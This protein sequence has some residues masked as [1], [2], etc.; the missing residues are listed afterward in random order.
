MPNG[1]RERGRKEGV[2]GYR[3]LL[4]YWLDLLAVMMST[5]NQKAALRSRTTF[6]AVVGGV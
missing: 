3:G 5:G 4:V 1:G 2:I 6:T